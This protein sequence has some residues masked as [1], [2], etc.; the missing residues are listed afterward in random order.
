M[1]T[2]ILYKLHS[3]LTL[4]FILFKTAGWVRWELS[5][6]YKAWRDSSVQWL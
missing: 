1:L 4:T 3:K 2:V 5:Q 6:W